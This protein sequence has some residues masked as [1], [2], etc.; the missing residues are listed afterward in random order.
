M[1]KYPH[2]TCV[3]GFEV[4]L[5]NKSA[6]PRASPLSLA[7]RPIACLAYLPFS[8]EDNDFLHLGTYILQP[9]W[10]FLIYLM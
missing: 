4:L 8:S 6:K 10:S 5:L 3:R 7:N 9:I 1:F 2:N